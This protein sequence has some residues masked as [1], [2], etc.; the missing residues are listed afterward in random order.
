LAVP[1]DAAIAQGVRDIPQSYPKQVKNMKGR[2][3][4]DAFVIAV[5]QLKKAVVG[6]W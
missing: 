4:A 1:T 2:H 3:R 6:D 5:A